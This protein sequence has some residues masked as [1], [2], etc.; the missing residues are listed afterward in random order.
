MF[1]N[2]QK[3]DSI[4]SVHFIWKELNKI[5]NG[6]HEHII[7]A[8]KERL[9]TVQLR[10]PFKI[11]KR[12]LRPYIL[13]CLHIPATSIWTISHIYQHIHTILVFHLLCAV[14]VFKWT[15]WEFLSSFMSTLCLRLSSSSFLRTGS[16][17]SGFSRLALG[18]YT[19]KKTRNQQK[20]TIILL[21]SVYRV[22]SYS[23]RLSAK[24]TQRDTQ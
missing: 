16:K 21:G 8:Y 2:E 5:K 18:V 1:G 19:Y 22:Q 17:W 13:F 14:N 20:K 11:I 10:L 23:H 24:K 9:Y 4:K 6:M 12:T 7:N 15:Y 3:I